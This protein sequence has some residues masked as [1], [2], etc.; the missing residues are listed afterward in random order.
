MNRS[1][2]TEEQMIGVLRQSG[3]TVADLAR[4]DRGKS[5][6][7]GHPLRQRRHSRVAFFQARSASILHRFTS[8]E[9]V[10]FPR[11]EVIC[12]SHPIATGE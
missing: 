10:R 4:A 3:R 2:Q 12:S 1:K 6:R 7:L 9:I 8:K 5:G 11:D